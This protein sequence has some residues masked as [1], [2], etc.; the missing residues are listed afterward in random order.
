MT[1]ERSCARSC[2]HFWW[3]RWKLW[4]VHQ[5]SYW[6]DSYCMSLHCLLYGISAGKIDTFKKRCIFSTLFPKRQWKN[7]NMHE[8]GILRDLQ[9]LETEI[10]LFSCCH[11]ERIMLWI[12]SRVIPVAYHLWSPLYLHATEEPT[13]GSRKNLLPMCAQAVS[14]AAS[15]CWPICVNARERFKWRLPCRLWSPKGTPHKQSIS[16]R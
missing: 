10:V 15:C 16:E 6:I 1:T 9:S 7:M 11:L 3:S 8:S 12:L 4:I 2:K 13:Q 5:S 14:W